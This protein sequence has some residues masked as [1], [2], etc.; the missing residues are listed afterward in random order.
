MT[1]GSGWNTDAFI[2][3]RTSTG[4]L[5]DV[6]VRQALSLALDRRGIIDTVYKGAATLPRTISPPGTFGYGQ[7]VFETAD[8]ALPEMTQNLTKAKQLMQEA[9]AAGKTITLGMS[10]GLTNNATEAGA[11]QA[12]ASAIGLKVKSSSRSRADNYIN[13]FIDAKT[14][15][16]TDGFMTMNYGD[17][18]DP[19]ALL[20]SFVLSTG[21][22]N[23]DGYSNAQVT[24]LMDKA[25]GTADPNARAQNVS[26]ARRCCSRTTCRGSRTW[27]PKRS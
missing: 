3:R 6:R 8:D 16:G 19:A 15:E 5:G 11:Y 10:R 12:A 17:Y 1:A 26:Q 25:R 9:G 24:R 23:Y 14:R 22:Q 27:S 2:D 4:P 13:F 18:A 20:A 21:S 7:S